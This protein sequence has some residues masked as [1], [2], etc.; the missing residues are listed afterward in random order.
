MLRRR[1]PTNLLIVTLLLSTLLSAAPVAAESRTEWAETLPTWKLYIWQDIGLIMTP[2][3]EEQFQ[4]IGSTDDL[5][6]WVSAFWVLRDPTPTTELNERR[7]EHFK[8]LETART[9]YP[10]ADISGLDLR[11]RDYVFLGPPDETILTDSWFDETGFHRSRDTWIWLD[12]E[13][14]ATYSDWN[15]NGEWGQ[16]WDEVPS[17][18]PDVKRRLENAY[19]QSGQAEDLEVIDELRLTNP[20]AYMDLVRQFNEGETINPDDVKAQALVGELLGPKF[21]RMEGNYFRMRKERKDPYV[22]D[23]QTEPLWSVFAVDCFRGTTGRTRVEVTH[24]VR[25]CDLAMQWDFKEELFRGELLRRVTFFDDDNDRIA[26]SEDRIPIRAETLDDTRSGTLIPGIAVQDLMPGTY[27]LALRLE[28]TGSGKLQIYQVPVTV[29]PF[30]SE[31][32]EL[33][34]ITFASD[35]HSVNSPSIFTKGEWEVQPHPLRM[36]T[37]NTDLNIFF[38][39]YGLVTDAQGLNEYTVTYRIRPKQPKIK[40][41][42]LWTKSEVVS[43]EIGSTFADRHGGRMARHP[44]SV[45]TGEFAED[46]YILEIEVR[47]L[48]SEQS[49]SKRANFSVMPTTTIR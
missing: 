46:T 48:Q 35:I 47:D 26:T 22:H 10:A 37:S 17:T 1:V 33:S 34:D 13:M 36:Y 45:G 20:D 28:D 15:L 14:R 44:L 25:I 27:R 24:Q 31:E 5:N 38:E 4:R 30:T 21:R 32:L 6:A 18:R 19:L 42:W 12:L 23:F 40:S 29:V 3:E 2:A 11:G 41:G 39:V 43:S 49:V 9:N 7:E 16:A 8:R